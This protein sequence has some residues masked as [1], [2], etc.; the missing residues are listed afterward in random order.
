MDVA[1]IFNTNVTADQVITL[2]LQEFEIEPI[3]ENKAEN[4]EKLNRFL[5]DRY[6]KGVR[7]LLIIDEA[8]NLSKEALEEVRMLSNLQSDDQMLLQIVLVGQPNLKLKLRDPSLTQFAQRISV[9][10]HLSTLSQGETTRYIDF[11]LK[12]AGRKEALFTTGALS[13][14]FKHSKGIPRSI[15]LLCDAALV[16]GFADELAVI[17]TDVIDQVLENKV[18]IGMPDEL[19]GET[20]ASLSGPENSNG[21]MINKRLEKLEARFQR[22]EMAVK[23]QVE[24]L[25]QKAE[26][27]K[28]DLVSNLNKL[29]LHERKKK[30]ILIN[31]YA[32]LQEKYKALIRS[33]RKDKR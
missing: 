14:I 6:A 11:R 16:Y 30:E 24:E 32:Q 8:Q 1:V 13:D 15:N 5:I 17:D 21:N 2:I 27:Y 3:A 33:Q 31:K 9:N 23:W 29:L 10:Y 28:D 12:M 22:L 20:M 18:G 19:N 26:G 4:L 25:Q 7:A